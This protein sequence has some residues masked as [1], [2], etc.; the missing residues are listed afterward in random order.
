M[1]VVLVAEDVAGIHAMRC[2]LENGQRIVAVL[3]GARTQEPHA[4]TPRQ[5][6][7]EHNIPV[8][9][10]SLVGDA[11]FASRLTAESVDL[12]LNVHSLRPVHAAVA[13]APLAGTFNLHPGPLPHYAGANVVSWALYRGEVTYGCTLHWTGGLNAGAAAYESGFEVTESDSALTLYAK[14]VSAG[15]PLITQLL[16]DLAH[17]SVPVRPL[18]VTAMQVYS[19]QVPHDGCVRWSRPASDIVNFVRACDYLPMRSPWGHPRARVR[20]IEFMITKATRT[21]EVASAAPG[22]V[23]PIMGRSV[24]V[25]GL[26]EWVLVNRV[27]TDGHHFDAADLLRAGDHIHDGSVYIPARLPIKVG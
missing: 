8:W 25:A 19:D 10:L 7:H 15:L 6:A 9:P 5:F 18:D 13:R 21:Y 2:L 4:V 22:V 11:A 27:Y 17:G 24:C 20:D 26:D 1:N 23:G 3:T 14:C 16:S 12:L